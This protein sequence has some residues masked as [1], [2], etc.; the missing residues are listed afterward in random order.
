MRAPPKAD[1]LCV[2]AAEAPLFAATVELSMATR[3][4]TISPAQ[5]ISCSS[6]ACNR[7]HTPRRVQLRKRRQQVEPLPQQNAISLESHSPSRMCNRDAGA[8]LHAMQTLVVVATASLLACRADAPSTANTSLILRQARFSV[9]AGA[10][11]PARACSDSLAYFARTAVSGREGWYGT[12]LAAL[13]E[14]VLCQPRPEAATEVYRLTWLPTF[15]STVVVRIDTDASGLFLTAKMESGAG[16][17][18]PGHLA[19]DTTFKLSEIQA[20]QFRDLLSASDFWR[21][22]TM[23]PP[24]NGVGADGAQWLFEGVANSRYHVVDRWTPQR[25]GTDSRYRTLAEW[26]LARSGLASAQ[27]VQE[28]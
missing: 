6:S 1:H 12:H 17:Y 28:Y 9:P 10:G 13:H 2:G 26:L 21:L 11:I 5:L 8:R 4:Q 19:R 18:D 14:P 7:F 15:H 25:D 27:L 16:G 20:S 23:P 22:P 24:G 3:V